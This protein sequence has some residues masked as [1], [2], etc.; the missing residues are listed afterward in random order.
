MTRMTKCLLILFLLTAAGCS[1]TGEYLAQS[2]T[3][4]DLSRNNYRVVRHNAVGTSYGFWLLGFL[5]ITFPSHTTAMIDL[6]DNAQLVEGK[7]Q[8]LVNVTQDRSYLYLILFGIPSLTVRADIIEFT[9]EQSPSG[10][11]L[12]Y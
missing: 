3:T 11:K 4:V 1:G 8:A 6:Y 2:G 7:A 9:D 12:R 5:P 10:N